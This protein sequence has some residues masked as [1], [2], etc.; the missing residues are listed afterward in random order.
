MWKLILYPAKRIN[1]NN[2]CF[3]IIIDFKYGKGVPGLIVTIDVLK[4]R[5]YDCV[6]CQKQRLIVTIDVLKCDHATKI[7]RRL[8]INSNNRCFEIV[9]ADILSDREGRLIVT[10]DVLK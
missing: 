4:F 8:P 1:S 5:L 9:I 2:R 6:D 10:I 7:S 3:E